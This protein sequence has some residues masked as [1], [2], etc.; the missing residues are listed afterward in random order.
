VLAADADKSIAERAQNVLLSLPIGSFQAALGRADTDPRFFSF[1]AQFMGDKPG[2]ADALAKNPACP[3]AAVARVARHLTSEGIQALLADL[4]R[5]ISDPALLP[6]L[7]QSQGASAAQQALLSEIHERQGP[8]EKDLGE[9]AALVEPDPVKRETLTKKIMRMNVVERL[10]LAL[11]GDRE[12]RMLLIRDPNKLVQKCVLQSPRVTDTEVESFAAMGNVSEEVLRTIS[13]T[14]KFMKSYT[15]AKNLVTNAKTPIDISLH[16]VPRLT[17]T[18]LKLL[19]TNKNIPDT[20]RA[21][22][23]KLHRQRNLANQSSH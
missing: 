19:T 5:L 23:L 13:L 14:R 1:C 21:M 9:A 4:E 11:K 8:S 22:A 18:D 6:A 16:L 10:T 20:L 7:A 2:V 12:A 15:I 17:A 3:S